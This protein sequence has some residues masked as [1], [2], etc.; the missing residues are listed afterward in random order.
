MGGLLNYVMMMPAA[1]FLG[2]ALV[3]AV[4]LARDGIRAPLICTAAVI[5]LGVL[6][7]P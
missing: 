1:V 3:I 5:T 4:P 7:L 2:L 6:M